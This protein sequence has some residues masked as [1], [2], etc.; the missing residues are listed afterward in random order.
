MP[1]T[2]FTNRTI[3]NVSGRE[4]QLD[5]GVD[6]PAGVSIVVNGGKGIH[7]KRD[8]DAKFGIVISA[9]S[10]PE[11]Q[12]FGRITLDPHQGGLNPVT[13]PV[14]FYKQQGRSASST[15]A[16]R[17]RSSARPARRTAR[18]R[19]RTSTPRPRTWSCW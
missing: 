16:I 1:G 6:A 19:R 14:A 9:P 11:G 4:L 3:T 12:Y 15:A 10:L 5:V 18:W 13:I 17:R 7:V 2:V 8:Q